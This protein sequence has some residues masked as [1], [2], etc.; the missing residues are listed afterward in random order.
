MTL[1]RMT[2]SFSLFYNEQLVQVSKKKNIYLFFSSLK[3][4]KLIEYDVYD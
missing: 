3:E 1:I 2:E 4:M